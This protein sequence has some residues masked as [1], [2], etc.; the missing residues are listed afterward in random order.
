MDQDELQ[1]I[2]E[3]LWEAQRQGI[4]YPSG[5]KGRLRIEEAYQAL[6]AILERFKKG[7]EE[8][9]GWKLGFFSQAI[10][11][12][13]QY[14]EHLFGFLLK[15]NER[16]SGVS[17]EFDDLI[18]PSFENELCF[19]IGSDLKG[20]DVTVEQARAAIVRVAPAIEIVEKRGEIAADPP[21]AL[22]DNIQHRYF[23]TGPEIPLPD[24]QSL[25]EISAQVHI[26]GEMVGQAWGKDVFGDPAL[27]VAWLANSLHEYGLKLK[28]G[29]KVMSGSLTKQFPL[30]K[31]DFI[32]TDFG[33]LGMVQ[34]EIV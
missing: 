14:S 8:Q 12:Q 26:N 31:G 21:L 25:K 1:I 32:E 24:S 17:I 10:Q 27:A 33:P 9:A 29:Q 5:L 34:L 20:P 28:A 2:V 18:R 6:L 30:A 22:A 13:V 16:P 3:E 15:K 23:V 11:E 7:G 4:H 19:V